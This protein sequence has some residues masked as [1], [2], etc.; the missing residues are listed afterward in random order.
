MIKLISVVTLTFLLTSCA[1]IASKSTYD[2]MIQSAPSDA[3]FTVT[4]RAGDQLF[5]GSTPATVNLKA[6]SGYFKN[7]SYV[8]SIEKEGLAPKTYTLTSTV[9]GWYWGNLL[10]GGLIGMVVVDP[11]TGAMYKLPPTVDIDLE[12]VNSDTAPG[13]L[14]VTSIDNIS[15]EQRIHLERL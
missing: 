15:S 3:Q 4:N 12:P 10:L 9:D 7:E 8:I 5:T 14:S 13:D 11:A 1:S 2:V 6:S